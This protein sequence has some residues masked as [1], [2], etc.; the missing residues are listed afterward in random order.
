MT[1]GLL[2]TVL[3][4]FKF[5]DQTILETSEITFISRCSRNLRRV[6]R[7]STR[8][9]RCPQVENHVM[10]QYSYLAV[11]PLMMFWHQI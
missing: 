3:Q 5:Q 9:Q 2:C 4:D 1:V 11:L 8:Y 6:C 7:Q 10:W